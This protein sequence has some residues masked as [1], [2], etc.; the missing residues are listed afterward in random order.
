MGTLHSL[1]FVLVLIP[2]QHVSKIAL[3]VS[4][5]LSL[6]LTSCHNPLGF[7]LTLS[8]LAKHYLLFGL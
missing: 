3:I 5:F 2:D 4:Y 6:E 1:G 8:N 7:P